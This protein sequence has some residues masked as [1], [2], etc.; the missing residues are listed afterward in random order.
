MIYFC[1]KL[2]RV[3]ILTMLNM[4]AVIIRVLHL[5]MFS[6]WKTLYT[7][8]VSMFK[9]CFLTV[10]HMLFTGFRYRCCCCCCML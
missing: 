3:Q 1:V 9:I 2:P 10:F 6:V 4:P 8:R 5:Y 7:M